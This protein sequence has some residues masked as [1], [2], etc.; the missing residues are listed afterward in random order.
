[1]LKLTRHIL[2]YHTHTAHVNCHVSCTAAAL[3]PFLRA[4]GTDLATCDTIAVP[5]DQ[6]ASRHALPHM[7][8][9]HTHMHHAHEQPQR[10]SP[11]RSAATSP[12]MIPAHD[13]DGHNVR[14]LLKGIRKRAT[15]GMRASRAH[16]GTGQKIVQERSW[17]R[18]AA[19]GADLLFGGGRVHSAYR[20]NDPG[21]RKP[22]PACETR[23]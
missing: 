20:W 10:H 11:I 4:R 3:P 2:A 14:R 17:R 18:S 5:S 8:M 15:Q 12:A 23:S 13:R 16:C 7:H 19:R 6:F 21:L 22:N 9:S 1:L